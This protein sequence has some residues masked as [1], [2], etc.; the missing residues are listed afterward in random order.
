VSTRCSELSLAAGE[1]LAATAVTAERW[2][3]VEVPGPWPRDVG[4]RDALP[5]AARAA[6]DDWLERVPRSRLQFIR[7]TSR[8]AVRSP[9]V[10]VVESDGA[11]RE[12]RRIELER[13]GGLAT[14]DLDTAGTVVETP[15]VLVCGHGSRD[16]CCAQRGTAVFAALVERLGD[17]EL[18][19][20]SH[21]GGHRFAANVVVLPA[22][23][24]LGRVEPDE[25]PLVVARALA[26]R[27]ELGRYRGRTFHPQTVQAAEHAVRAAAGLAGVDELVL[28]EVEGD[29]VRFRAWDGQTWA[30]AVDEI[31]GPAVPASCGDEPAP[32][33]AFRATVLDVAA[34]NGRSA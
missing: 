26:G 2:L 25:A 12:V 23:V 7:R 34:S 11:R 4:A 21:L 20:A 1:T 18:W 32:Q 3:L 19:I 13:H 22:G 33:R 28:E 31:E 6:V 8:A 30:A 27:I 14:V 17:E 10:F 29:R 16:R 5:V 9:L 24:Q 15:L